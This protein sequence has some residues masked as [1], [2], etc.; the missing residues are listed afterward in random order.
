MELNHVQDFSCVPTTL[1]HGQYDRLGQINNRVYERNVTDKANRPQ[2][3][4]RSVAT[5][6]TEVFPILD[7]R[8]AS[9][10]SIQDTAPRQGFCVIQENILRSTDYKLQRGAEKEMYIPSSQSDMYKVE[11]PDSSTDGLQLHPCLF[12]REVYTTTGNRFIAQS[13][14]GKDIFNNNTKTQLRCI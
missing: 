14:I 5:R 3:D 4:M 7:I 11:I 2:F 1:L 10:V 13:K 6:Y 9:R 12:N 8:K